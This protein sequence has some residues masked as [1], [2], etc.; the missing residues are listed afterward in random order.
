MVYN[1]TSMAQVTKWE[2]MG[3]ISKNRQ[4][5]DQFGCSALI[6]I[7]G[8]FSKGNKSTLQPPLFSF[9]AIKIRRKKTV[10]LVALSNSVKI[11]QKQFSLVYLDKVKQ[12]QMT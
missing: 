6:D 7:S 8:Q 11:K 2:D 3:G 1:D 10:L 5:Q 4:S 12:Y 9:S